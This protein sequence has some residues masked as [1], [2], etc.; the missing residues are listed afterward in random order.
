MNEAKETIQQL[1]D[2]GKVFNYHNFS[3][4][5]R[6]GYPE[7][8]TA[9]WVTWKTRVTGAISGLFGPDAAPTALLHSASKVTLIGN[10]SDKF[11]H[12]LAHYLGALQ[13]ALEILEHDAFGEILRK[14]TAVAPHDLTNK[15]FIVHGHDEGAKNELEIMLRDMGLDPVILHR[16]VDG[17]RTIIEK[18]EDHADVGYAFILMTPDEIAYVIADDEKADDQRKK[19]YRA[20]PNVIWEFGYF[21][22]RLGRKRT[23]CLHRGKMT[24]PSD[25]NGLIYKAFD[26]SVEEIGWSIQK[27]LR[28]LGYK[29]R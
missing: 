8:L 5:S 26:K 7:A 14:E 4:K 3:A 24:M 11:A 15:V 19:E 29:L 12:A 25:L 9:D 10:D 22:G 18:F 28:A 13:S 27:E 21:V 23:C 16:Q 17:G 2:R 20:R 1:L 6:S